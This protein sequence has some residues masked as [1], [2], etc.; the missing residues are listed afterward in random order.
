MFL[1]GVFQRLVAQHVE[2]P[3]NP[4]ASISRQDHFVDVAALRS[5]EW[6][7]EPPLIFFYALCDF[8]GITK[9]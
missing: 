8:F 3:G 7:S 6:I 4:Y 5:N 2:R 1:P 9:L